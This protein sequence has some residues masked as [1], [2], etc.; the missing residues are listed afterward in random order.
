LQDLKTELGRLEKELG[1][2]DSM[3]LDLGIGK[4][5]PDQAIR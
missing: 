3:P 4:A 5:L 1:L 2:P